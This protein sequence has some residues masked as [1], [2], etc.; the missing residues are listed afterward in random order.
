MSHQENGSGDYD[1]GILFALTILVII[2]LWIILDK[3]PVFVHEMENEVIS[4]SLKMKWKLQKELSDKK[5]NKYKKLLEEAEKAART[6][7]NY[8]TIANEAAESASIAVELSKETVAD[9]KRIVEEIT[10]IYMN[11]V[12]EEDSK[13]E[14]KQE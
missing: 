12:A 7:E 10:K 1:M 3:N 2:F 14:V 9:A 6:A 13:I 11:I 5:K 8:M 4:S